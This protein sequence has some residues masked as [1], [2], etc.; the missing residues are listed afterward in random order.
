MENDSTLK[1]R[2]LIYVCFSGEY[3]QRWAIAAFSSR[4]I[5]EEYSEDVDELELGDSLPVTATMH[6]V[7]GIF[8][9]DPEYEQAP[10]GYSRRGKWSIKREK[11]RTDDYQ[12]RAM[13]S[14]IIAPWNR[15]R[16]YVEVKGGCLETI[17]DRF[18]VLQKEVES[19]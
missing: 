10:Y 12:V 13:S 7:A 2:K 6:T 14:E 1:G 16:T 15:P 5:A 9:A 18:A 19:Q 17:L 8:P 4:E 11:Y 3:E